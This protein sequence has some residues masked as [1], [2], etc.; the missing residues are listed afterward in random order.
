[1]TIGRLGSWANDPGRQ[2]FYPIPVRHNTSLPIA[3]FGF[4]FAVDT[5]AFGYKI[6]VITALSGLETTVSHPLDVWH[7]RHTKYQT[8]DGVIL[9]RAHAPISMLCNFFAP[10]ASLAVYSTGYNIG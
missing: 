8:P 1:M 5:L 2:A 4:H 9:I 6:P 10:F 3:S 7:A